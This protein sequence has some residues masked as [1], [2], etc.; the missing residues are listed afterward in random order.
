MALDSGTR[1]AGDAELVRRVAQPERG[2]A[3]AAEAEL[4]RRFAPRILLYGLKHLRSEE[5][6]RELVQDVLLAVLEALRAERIEHPEHLARYVLGTCRHVADRIRRED[7]RAE[8]VG[9]VPPEIA[10]ALPQVELLDFGAIV[11]C[12]DRL[13]DRARAVL[14][15]SFFRERSAD[16]I[17]DVLATT[18]G[19]VRVLRHRAIAA[20]RRCVEHGQESHP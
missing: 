20:L 12:L 11:H 4:C 19:N 8:P 6:A 1:E 16:E 10:T 5:R 3:R 9:L 7:G 14:Q 18:G 17:A 15:L 13:D 2:D